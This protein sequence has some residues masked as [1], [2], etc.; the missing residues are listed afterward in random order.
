MARFNNLITDEG[1]HCFGWQREHL[2]FK[3]LRCRHSSGTA[4]RDLDRE[5]AVDVLIRIGVAAVPVDTSG[6][7]RLLREFRSFF[8]VKVSNQ[9]IRTSIHKH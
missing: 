5:T 7:R 8:T 1:T 2:F 6:R 9:L 4:S 3:N